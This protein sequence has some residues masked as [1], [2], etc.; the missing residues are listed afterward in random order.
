MNGT[1]FCAKDFRD[2]T[3]AVPSNS[4]IYK[5]WAPE[6][7]YLKI[8]QKLNVVPNMIENEVQKSTIEGIGFVCIYVGQA[9]DLKKRLGNHVKGCIDKSTL[10]KSLGAI[11][12]DGECSS[13]DLENEINSFVNKL[14]VEYEEIESAE[15]D[16]AESSE[17]RAYL[18]V[19]NIDGF[20]HDSF[21]Q[22]IDGPLSELRTDLKKIKE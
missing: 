18:R 16:R 11:L 8:L 13:E 15:L 19:L 10:R 9:N 21:M 20:N 3:V 1:P 5:W 12:W 14:Y 7:C 17:I 2:G 6:E 22:Y 4:G